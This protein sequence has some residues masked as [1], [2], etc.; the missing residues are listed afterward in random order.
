MEKSIAERLYE[1]LKEKYGIQGT[2]TFDGIEF[3]IPMKTEI[4]IPGVAKNNSE[5]KWVAF[6]EKQDSEKID[7][8]IIGEECKDDHCSWS[9]YIEV[10][11]NDSKI[12]FAWFKIINNT[13][14]S[15]EYD[16]KSLIIFI[17]VLQD[18]SANI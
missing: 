2:E 18:F 3:D 11:N 13:H 8:L 6:L 16:F 1:Y 14:L 9:R 10:K 12:G 17:K 7:A 4:S 15:H 5:H